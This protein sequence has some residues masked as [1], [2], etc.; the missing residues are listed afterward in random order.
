MIPAPIKI[1]ADTEEYFRAALA[2]TFH[3]QDAAIVWSPHA[4]DGDEKPAVILGWYA[5]GKRPEDSFF[6]LFGHEVSIMPTTLEHI[7][8]KTITRVR[9]DTGLADGAKNVYVLEV[10]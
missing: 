2:G 3:H 10:G 1:A 9:Y 5:K 8:G 7:E 4:K 6:E